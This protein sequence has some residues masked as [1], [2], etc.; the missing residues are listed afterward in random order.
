MERKASI[1]GP[2]DGH[3]VQRARGMPMERITLLADGTDDF[4]V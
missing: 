1:Q 2:A 4:I 3:T